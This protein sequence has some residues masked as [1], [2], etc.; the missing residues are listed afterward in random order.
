M[1]G[2]G[3]ISSLIFPVMIDMNTKNYCI[4]WW[5]FTHEGGL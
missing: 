4:W 3:A 1:V 5:F 2:F